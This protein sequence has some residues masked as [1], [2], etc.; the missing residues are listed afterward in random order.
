MTSE[1]TPAKA[2]FVC[3]SLQTTSHRT[4]SSWFVFVISL[5]FMLAGFVSFADAQTDNLRQSSRRIQTKQPNIILINLD[6]ADAELLADES[7]QKFFPAINSIARRGIQFTNT[8]ATTPLCG[9]SR[10]CLLRAQYSHRTGIRVN[11]PNSP[12]SYGLDGGFKSYLDRGYFDD[13]LSTWMQSAGY[14]TMMVGKFLHPNFIKY[15]PPGWDDFRS[16]LGGKYY[17]T[18]VFTNQVKPDGSFYELPEGTYRTDAESSDAVDVIEKHLATGS[19]KPFFLFLNPFGPH[20]QQ[21]GSGPMIN[22]AKYEDHLQGLTPPAIDQPD[23][24]SDL[25]DDATS[26]LN[27][28][29]PLTERHVAILK[30]HYRERVLATKSVD[31]L[32]QNLIDLLDAHNLTEKTYIFITSDNGFCLG[33][34]RTIG[35][36]FT[37]DRASKIPL[38]VAGPGTAKNETANQLLAHIDIGPTIVELAG[39][40]A[41]EFVDGRSFRHVLAEPARHSTK[42]VRHQVLIENYESR[43]IFGQSLDVASTSLRVPNALYTEWA[44][45]GREYYHFA[46]DPAQ[47]SNVYNDVSAD[48]KQILSSRI[49]LA[50]VPLPPTASFQ[51]PFGEDDVLEFPAKLKGIAEADTSISEVRIAIQEVNSGLY[52]NG[53]QWQSEF[54]NVPAELGNPESPLAIWE[55]AFAPPASSQRAGEY[56]TW[57]WTINDQ[58]VF[59]EPRSIKFRM[60]TKAST[61]QP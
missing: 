9:P 39:G 49:R 27:A 41:P 19:R 32:V 50:K 33:H 17:R 15:V 58:G 45:G 23:D 7:L 37:V 51:T 54:V 43:S 18:H 1:F 13:D 28:M 12:I 16:Y 55:Y 44:D 22:T 47:H 30:M 5:L 21:P 40:Q 26:P 56:K 59:A 52:W 8:H 53:T 3:E 36:G 2:T 4:A 57:A 35:K 60:E 11:D 6:D 10:A 42:A 38:I 61:Q 14:R 29:E 24:S 48:Q 34:H 46:S 31:E 25:T 20:R